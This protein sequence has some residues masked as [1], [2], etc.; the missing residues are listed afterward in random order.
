MSS[1]VFRLFISMNNDDFQLLSE[2][3]KLW[4]TEDFVEK[5]LLKRGDIVSLR[6]GDKRKDYKL[7]MQG[8]TD[9]VKA[10]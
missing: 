10:K 3:S 4:L 5:I 8:G 9:E 7:V 2:S 6:I 1:Q